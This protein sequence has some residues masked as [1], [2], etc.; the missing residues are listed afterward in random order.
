MGERAAGDGDAAE[1]EVADAD[2]DEGGISLD[3]WGFFLWILK[4]FF[5]GFS[6]PLLFL[7]F[8]TIYRSAGEFWG[9][10]FP[11]SF[12]KI[13]GGRRRAGG[14]REREEGTMAEGRPLRAWQGWRWFFSK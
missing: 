11:S 9:I 8:F 12:A 7:H 3:R 4:M 13:S 2:A 10:F 6:Y 14:E 1:A 5:I